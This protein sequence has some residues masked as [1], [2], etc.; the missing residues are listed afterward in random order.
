MNFS[1]VPSGQVPHHKT[2]PPIIQLTLTESFLSSSEEGPRLE[3]HGNKTN[4]SVNSSEERHMGAML[5]E[6]YVA[7]QKI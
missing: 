6:T 5:W 2:C 1:P 4:C 3:H 7:S